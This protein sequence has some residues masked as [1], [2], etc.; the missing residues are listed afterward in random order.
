[1]PSVANLIKLGCINANQC[2]DDE[3][4]DDESEEHDVEFLEAREHTSE[5]LEPP[6]QALELAVQNAVLRPPVHARVDGVPVSEVLRQTAPLAAVLGHVEN[7]IEDLQV[8]EA[9][10]APLPQQQW[11]NALILYPDEFHLPVPPHC[12]N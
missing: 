3:R 11:H 10:I 12:F 4:E 2:I 8:R 7:G 5:A 6:E 1:M 9:D